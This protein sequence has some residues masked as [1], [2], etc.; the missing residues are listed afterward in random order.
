MLTLQE[1]QD[2]IIQISADHFSRDPSELSAETAFVEDLN[3]DSLDMVEL[4]MEFEETFEIAVP[5]DA[6]DKIKTIGAATA[7]VARHMDPAEVG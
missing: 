1:T 2:R 3:A 5:D 7:F 6:V 4:A